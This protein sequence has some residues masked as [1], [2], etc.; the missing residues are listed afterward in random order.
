MDRTDEFNRRIHDILALD[1]NEKIDKY[2]HKPRYS[3]SPFVLRAV[4]MLTQLVA[5]EKVVRKVFVDYVDYH[6][7]LPSKKSSMTEI[8]R[9]EL[10]KEIALFI[11]TYVTEVHELK[12][13]REAADDPGK[14]SIKHQTEIVSYLLER[15]SRLNKRVQFMQKERQTCSKKP[16]RLTRGA[17][18][19]T[20]IPIAET[21]SSSSAPGIQTP[22]STLSSSPPS[23][24]SQ[25]MRNE[26]SDSFAERYESEIAPPSKMREY[27]TIA[28]RHRVSLLKE[29][30]QMQEKF[31]TERKEAHRMEHTVA[32][33][34][35]MLDE[36]VRILQ[37][38]S[39]H[40]MDVHDTSKTATDHVKQT[41]DELQLTIERSQ[42]HRRNMVALTLGLA[43][44]LLLLDYITP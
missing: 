37:H 18:D 40:V 15:L 28:S 42:S 8:E 24:T 36:F 43:I 14:P 34:S 19:N 21:S 1:T 22:V 13:N 27:Q 23:S 25:M 12:R 33:I 7:Y 6:K 11:A 35:T 26:V 32:G 20:S 17:H 5:M 9:A 2:L 31:S 38:Q 30:R 41:S 10:D 4:E 44:L 3:P 16:F 29:T 39:E